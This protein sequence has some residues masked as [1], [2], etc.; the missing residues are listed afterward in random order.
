MWDLPGLRIEPVSSVLSDKFLTP[1]HQGSSLR[2]NLITTLWDSLSSEI[3][4]SVSS[5]FY[6]GFYIFFG[7]TYSSIYAPL[8]AQR[9]KR[10]SAMQETWVQFLGQEDPLEKEMAT[11]SSILAWRICGWRRLVGYSPRGC[12]ELDTTEWLHFTSLHFTW[13]PSCLSDRIMNTVKMS[14]LHKFIYRFNAFPSK[15]PITFCTEMSI[16]Q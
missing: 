8:V 13:V 9:V 11:H 15:I 16:C 14:K 1:D 5:S 2:R 10:L 12:K 7:G 3:L 4:I 6:L